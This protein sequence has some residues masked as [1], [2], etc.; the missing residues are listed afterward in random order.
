MIIKRVKYD[1]YGY[2]LFIHLRG[3][4]LVKWPS[5]GLSRLFSNLEKSQPFSKNC[6]VE[7][8]NSRKCELN[9]FY[10]LAILN[11][12]RIFYK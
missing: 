11:N 4:E 1:K 2:V 5:T 9:V 8:R 10:A 12:T 7:N 6:S 3:I